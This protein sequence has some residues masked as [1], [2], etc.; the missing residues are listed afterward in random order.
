VAYEL[1][2]P[3]GSMIHLV[4]HVSQLKKSMKVGITPNLQLPVISD[5]GKVRIEPLA[6]PDRRLV[7][8]NNQVKVE[9]LI[10]WSNLDEE[11]T[12]WEDY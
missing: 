5:G 11:K 3:A 8:R 12:T 1:N 10:R 7:K 4:F 9:V 2:L 6:I